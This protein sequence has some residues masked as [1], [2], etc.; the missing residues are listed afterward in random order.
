MSTP[1]TGM[2]DG[3]EACTDDGSAEPSP[4]YNRP[5]QPALAYRIGTHASFFHRMLARLPREALPDGDFAHTRPLAAL[6]TRS[7]EDPAVALLDAFA[8]AADVLTFYQE[9]IANE[10]FLRTATERRSVLELAREIGYELKPGVAA[11]TYLVFTV[12]TAPGSPEVVQVA[13][14]VQVLS[15]PGQDERP[16]TFETVEALEARAAWNELHPRQ[17]EPQDFSNT[18][19]QL[20]LQGLQT[21]L[22]PGDAL[23]LVGAE[24]EQSPGSERWDLRIVREVTRVTDLTD[25]TRNHTVVSWEPALGSETPPVP[26]SSN[27]RA[28]VLRLR[29]SLFGYNAADFRLLPDLVKDAFKKKPQDPRPTDYPGFEIQTA[30]DRL[31]DLDREYPSLVTGSW[32]VLQKS[33]Y[34]ELYRIQ[35]TK[36]YARVDFGLTGRVT[37][38]KVDALEHISWFPLRGTTV[39]A[40]SEELPLTEKPLTTVVEGVT[41]LLDREVPGLLAGHVF[42]VEGQ[43]ASAP[44]GPLVRERAV[45]VSATKSGTSTLLE[46]KEALRNV[47]VRSS[48]RIYGNVAEATHGE[49]VPGEVLGSGDGSRKNQRFALKK[50]PLTYV[51]A[52]TVTGGES[53]LQVF[54]NGV[55]WEQ[56]PTL[57]GQ[58]SLSQVYMVRH[59]DDGT[60]VLTFGDGVSGARLPTGQEN[61]VATYRS[62]IGP[63]GEVDSGQLALLRVRPLGIRAVTNPLDA[64]GAAA[65]ESRDDARSHA[66][67]SVL[68]L[69]RVV[70]LQDYEDFASTFAGIGKAQAADLTNG[71][72]ILVHLTVASEA[73]EA[74]AE[75]TPQ[76][77]ALVGALTQVH[78]PVRE[79]VVASFERITFRL[80]AKLQVDPRYV[81]DDVLARAEAALGQA[82]SFAARRFGQAVSAAEVIRVLQ[83]VA[84]VVMVDLD[85]LYL[86]TTQTLS[87]LLPARTARW[88]GTQMKP[89]QLLLLEWVAGSLEVKP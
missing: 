45:L 47:Y 83:E 81:V 61:V 22:V 68:T 50:P 88:E 38:L 4:L 31:F 2:D 8:T 89:A 42:I 67:S 60:V 84:G 46:F 78:D 87:S 13:E 80:K 69:D 10:G 23:L 3:C 16:Q 21:G 33:S 70:S 9:R 63:D 19:K 76:Y 53:T 57:F 55:R 28:Y 12:E 27:P 7:A 32:V 11:S 54:V 25:P 5:G 48:V 52:A 56:V 64:T 43:M 72:R 77:D 37:R 39:L 71:E 14:G 29:A 62:G 30:A 34:L 66:P 73:G 20:Y 24:R 82:F 86:G 85:A 17:T 18:T 40:Q 74:V 26:P 35:E 15:I 79:F 59:E 41:V 44:D 36:P 65:P 49:T 1:G 75:G 51:P 6:T 58:D